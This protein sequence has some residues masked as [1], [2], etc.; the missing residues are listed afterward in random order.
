MNGLV[1]LPDCRLGV[2]PVIRSMPLERVEET[3]APQAGPLRYVAI[4]KLDDRFWPGYLIDVGD[5]DNIAILW[6]LIAD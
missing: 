3:A 1:A 6:C 5:N 2:V 4:S